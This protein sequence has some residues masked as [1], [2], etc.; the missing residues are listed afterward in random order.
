M[1][2]KAFFLACLFWNIFFF[3]FF[4]GGKYLE[5]SKIIGTVCL[6]TAGVINGVLYY[7]AFLNK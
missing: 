5:K 6:L 1:N 4:F 2:Y 3:L 7:K